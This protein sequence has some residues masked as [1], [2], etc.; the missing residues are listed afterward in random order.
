MYYETSFAEV[1]VGDKFKLHPMGRDY[2][3]HTLLHGRRPGRIAF[4]IALTRRV[5][6]K[7]S[8]SK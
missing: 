2:Y 5:W 8:V 1:R 3:K 4:L 6:V 7:G